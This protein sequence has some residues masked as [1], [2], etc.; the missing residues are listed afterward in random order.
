MYVGVVDRSMRSIVPFKAEPAL[1]NTWPGEVCTLAKPGALRYL[2]TAHVPEKI[3]E[4][5]DIL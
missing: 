3:R 1:L 4:L 5:L 2:T